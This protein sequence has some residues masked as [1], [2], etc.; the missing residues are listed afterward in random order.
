[1][2]S[3]ILLLTV[4]FPILAIADC[5]DSYG[6]VVTAGK[7]GTR[8]GGGGVSANIDNSG[9]NKNW[10]DKNFCRA[11]INGTED[12]LL[13]QMFN[14]GTVS[15]AAVANRLYAIGGAASSGISTTV[16]LQIKLNGPKWSRSDHILDRFFTIT[17]YHCGSINLL[18]SVFCSG[19]DYVFDDIVTSPTQHVAKSLVFSNGQTFN[20]TV[21]NFNQ[22]ANNSMTTTYNAVCNGYPVSRSWTTSIREL[23]EGYFTDTP[24]NLSVN[25]NDVDLGLYSYFSPGSVRE[26]LGDGVYYFGNEWL[27]SPFSAGNGSHTLSMRVNNQGCYS[28]YRDTTFTVIGIASI[29]TPP[30]LSYTQ[31]FGPGEGGTLL[32]RRYPPYL[33]QEGNP[34]PGFDQGFGTFHF[35]CSNRDYT[36]Y[37][38]N[39]LSSLTY[40]WVVYYHNLIYQ[41]G[42]GNTLTV[43][44]PDRASVDQDV[45]YG[46]QAFPW[47]D[48]T[49]ISH[50]VKGPGD[51]EGNYLGDVLRVTVRKRNVINQVSN[52][53]EWLVGIVDTPVLEDNEKICY[54]ADPTL[55]SVSESEVYLSYPDE[56]VLRSMRWDIDMDGDWEFGGDSIIYNISNSN[57]VNLFKAQV[58]DTTKFWLYSESNNSWNSFIFPSVDE[59]CYSNIDTV[60][61]VKN[62]IMSVDF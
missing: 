32:Y 54:T 4:L 55:V 57:K 48:S 35:G 34:E 51:Y 40:E 62:P 15:W 53:S 23:R 18:P 25:S 39:P 37:V 59:V 58:V 26:F 22:P 36:F 1:M 2:K 46:Q 61:I 31:T 50:F 49:Y 42:T 47:P 27:F 16:S 60:R 41:T 33:D 13:G 21:I 43:S 14:S 28:E 9:C 3:I 29:T 17:V 56:T 12:Y 5:G 7:T 19:K 24:D 30:F 38:A 44:M 20:G 52:Y 8:G 6:N 45:Y 11:Y 10:N